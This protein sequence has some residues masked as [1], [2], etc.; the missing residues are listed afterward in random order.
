MFKKDMQK[1]RR[2]PHKVLEKVKEETAKEP[3][4]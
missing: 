2:M 4:K 3:Q 1:V